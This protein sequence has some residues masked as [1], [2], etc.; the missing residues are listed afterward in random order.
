MDQI[1]LGNIAYL[2]LLTAMVG[3]WFFTDT[4]Q[5]LGKSLRQALTW[6]LIILVFVAVVSLFMG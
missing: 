5:S 6:G 3:F 4:R 1:S 2:V